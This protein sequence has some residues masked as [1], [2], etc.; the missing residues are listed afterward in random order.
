MCCLT[1]LWDIQMASKLMKTRFASTRLAFSAWLCFFPFGSFSSFICLLSYVASFSYFLPDRGHKST[2]QSFISMKNVCE[3]VLTNQLVIKLCN[4]KMIYAQCWLM[5]M[6]FEMLQFFSLVLVIVANTGLF[7]K[8]YD[9]EMWWF[10]CSETPML[11]IVIN[12][13]HFYANVTF[14][15]MLNASELP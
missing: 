4:E 10:F 8:H 5:V 11:N 1:F 13:T 6:F 9:I 7:H 2:S 12:Q 3:N 14:I 15:R